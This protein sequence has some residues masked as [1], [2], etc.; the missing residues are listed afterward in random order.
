MSY[1]FAIS[2]DAG[3]IMVDDTY[4]VF[5]VIEQGDIPPSASSDSY[6]HRVQFTR[7]YADPPLLILY[8]PEGRPGWIYTFRFTVD[9][10]GRVD[11]FSA[12]LTGNPWRLLGYADADMLVGGSDVAI[13]EP[14]E[15]AFGWRYA[16]ATD[17]VPYG[18]EPYGLRVWNTA[19]RLVYDSAWPL[20][21]FRAPLGSSLTL[22]RREQIGNM[23]VYET[24]RDTYA[25]PVAFAPGAKVGILAS[26]W[27]SKSG[28]W[29]FSLALGFATAARDGV[30]V[31]IKWTKHA[32]VGRDWALRFAAQTP[33]L[34][35][36]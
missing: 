34:A 7:T 22:V 33:L 17:Q 21:Y 32:S 4:P 12:E 3:N 10:S 36:I 1:G 27:A 31:S 5:Q 19:G 18:E 13:I 6:L 2:G 15:R 35:A 8:P 30:S 11:G 29:D 25:A 9:A 24:F 14:S 28:N 20:A 26:T 16:V 23:G